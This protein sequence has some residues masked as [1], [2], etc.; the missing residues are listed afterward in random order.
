VNNG[1]SKKG[2]KL[3]RLLTRPNIEYRT[4]DKE[5]RTLTWRI[6]PNAK[7][8]ERSSPLAGYTHR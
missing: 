6:D 1:S 2:K 7:P 8:G 3:K 5:E 4:H